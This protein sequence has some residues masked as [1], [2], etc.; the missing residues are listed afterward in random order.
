MIPT[1]FTGKTELMQLDILSCLGGKV[2]LGNKIYM[3]TYYRTI[4]FR[5]AIR[6]PSH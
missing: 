6:E 3:Q 2:V 5:V 4:E 1:Q